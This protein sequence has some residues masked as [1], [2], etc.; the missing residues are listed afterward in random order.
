MTPADVTK[1]LIKIAAFDQRTVSAADVTAWHEI[2]AP[3]ALGDALA[4]VTRH[5][6][7]NPDRIKPAHVV[8]HVKAIRAEAARATSEALALPGK[9]EDDPARDG[10]MGPGIQACREA[11]ADIAEKWSMQHALDAG[12]LSPSEQLRQNAIKRAAAERRGRWPKP[13][14]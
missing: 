4:A 13:A 6:R 8:A 2:L 10:R 14:A 1:V 11:V 3:Y 5:H 7:D 9:F 12:E